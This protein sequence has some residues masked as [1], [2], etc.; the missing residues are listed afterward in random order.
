MILLIFMVRKF[1]HLKNVVNLNF[2]IY[3]VIHF[4]ILWILLFKN[5]L[6]IIFYRFYHFKMLI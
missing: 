1:C 5:L 4:Y 6:I 2:T 3:C